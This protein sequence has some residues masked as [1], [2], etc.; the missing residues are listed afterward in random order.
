MKQLI[1]LFVLIIAA[2]LV[3][4][5]QCP[6]EGSSAGLDCGD[7]N[8]TVTGDIQYRGYYGGNSKGLPTFDH[9][10]GPAPVFRR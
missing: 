8:L 7:S 4:S 1:P 6:C 3:S 10:T 2:A 9:K 5:C